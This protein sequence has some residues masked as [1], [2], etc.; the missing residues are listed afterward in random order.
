MARI[1]RKKSER[2]MKVLIG[3][4]LAFMVTGALAW[5]ASNHL[6]PSF[7]LSS[8][9]NFITLSW[10]NGDPSGDYNYGEKITLKITASN[11]VDYSISFDMAFY[12]TLPTGFSDAQI[13]LS[14]QYAAFPAPPTPIPTTD[15]YGYIT[16]PLVANQVAG[17]TFYL[18]IT[19]P[20]SPYMPETF[21]LDIVA[22]MS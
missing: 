3:L 1:K 17:L 5:I 9:E 22:Q 15:G 18:T 20:D 8:T 12:I 21:L 6:N 4:S 13:D 16:N 2:M 19:A 10:T 7:N 11:Q 14:Q